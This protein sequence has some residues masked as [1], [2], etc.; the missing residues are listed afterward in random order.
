MNNWDKAFSD[1]I[2]IWN[3]LDN[4]ATQNELIEALL[5]ARYMRRLLCVNHTDM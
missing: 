5:T 2:I 3:I 4:W 1:N